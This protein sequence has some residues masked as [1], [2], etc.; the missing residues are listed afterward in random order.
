MRSCSYLLAFVALVVAHAP[1]AYAQGAPAPATNS[2]E[3]VEEIVVMARRS[4]IPVWRVTSP[5]A[6]VILVGAIEEVSRG[7]RWDP[8]SLTSALRQADQIIFP[9]EEDFGA[10]PFAMVGY[11]VKF[12]RMAKL[13]KG[14]S[15]RQ[16]MP[17]DQFQ[18]LVTLRSRGLLKAGFERTHPLHLTVRL[19]DIIEGKKGYGPN[20][21]DYVKGAVKKYKL[22][23]AK[24]P[25]RNIKQP[26]NALFKSKPEAHIPCLLA[27][28]SLVEAGPQAVAARSEDWAARR[29]PEVVMALPTKVFA[30]CSLDEYLL[31]PP[32]WRAA[33]KRALTE[34]K[35][36][37][38]VL[39]LPSLARPGGLLDELSAL[40]YDV[41]GPSWKQPR[42]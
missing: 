16:M 30:Q 32:D 31:S 25:R 7:T 10:S 12:L 6:T 28:V 39:D 17:P 26:I 1:E 35:V 34:A 42:E 3:E 38:A 8:G 18:R 29:V 19:H 41:R 27:S 20:A 13:P 5:N 21:Q 11:L 33:V 23:Q 37:V 24:I 9:Q 36:T 22:N 14:Q 40:G 4:G 15:L 2:A